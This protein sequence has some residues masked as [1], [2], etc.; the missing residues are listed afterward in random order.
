MHSAFP[1]FI[2]QL[3]TVPSASLFFK[4]LHRIGIFFAPPLIPPKSSIA[5][6][7]FGELVGG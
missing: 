1:K 5:T 2:A 3:T 4:A 7:E 6:I